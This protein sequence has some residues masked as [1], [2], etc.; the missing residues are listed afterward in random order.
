MFWPQAASCWAHGLKF[1]LMPLPELNT[2]GGLAYAARFKGETATDLYAIVC[3]S[4]LPP[5][6][7][8]A[9]VVRGIDNP[10]ILKLIESGV[11]TWADGQRTYAFAYQRPIAPRMMNTLDETRQLLSEDSINHHF[12]TPMINALGAL[13]NAGVVHNAIRPTNIFWRIGNAA[14]P[15]IGECLSVPAGMG[16]PVIFEPIERSLAMPLGAAPG[17]PPMTVMLLA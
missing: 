3:M 5:R 2:A 7:D 8:A 16:Q 10:S 4:G 14:T 15:Q 17:F 11:V 12:I 13:A 1:F 9:A 6:I